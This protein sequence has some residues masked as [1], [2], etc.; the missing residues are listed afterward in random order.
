MYAEIT[1]VNTIFNRQIAQMHI[2]EK[3]G[4]SCVECLAE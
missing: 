3:S 2:L 4:R 1:R